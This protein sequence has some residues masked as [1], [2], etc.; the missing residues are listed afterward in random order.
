VSLVLVSCPLALSYEH[1]LFLLLAHMD[2]EPID[3]CT[4]FS[5]VTLPLSH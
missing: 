2:C 3:N 4:W 5:K 1:W